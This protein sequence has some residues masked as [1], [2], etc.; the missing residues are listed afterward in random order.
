VRAQLGSIQACLF[1]IAFTD[2][3][4]DLALLLQL[5]GTAQLFGQGQSVRRVSQL[6]C[7]AGI[8]S[9]GGARRRFSMLPS[10]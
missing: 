2:K 10:G 1:G 9:D 7:R 3:N 4:F 6:S 5:P 8:G